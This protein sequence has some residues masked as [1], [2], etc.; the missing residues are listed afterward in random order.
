MYKRQ[1]QRRAGT[2]DEFDFLQQDAEISGLEASFDTAFNIFGYETDA[3]ISYSLIEGDLDNGQNLPRIP[4]EKYTICLKSRVGETFINFDLIHAAKQNDVALN[5]LSTDSYTQVDLGL[6]WTPSAFNG[7]KVSTVIR[8]LTD[9]EIR[10]HTSA[11]KDLLPES[12]R[13]IR[14]SIGLSF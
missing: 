10:R 13:D 3:L 9:E 8:N 6:D 7:L 4:P 1:L 2:E 11:I 5:E 12:G 14:L